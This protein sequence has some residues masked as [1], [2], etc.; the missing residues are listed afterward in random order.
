MA[1]EEQQQAPAPLTQGQVEEHLGAF[2][3]D[4][5]QQPVEPR[6]ER[7]Q[8]EQ[9]PQYEP[10]Q[11]APQ[12]QGQQE[13]PPSLE[14]DDPE[15]DWNGRKYKT[16]EL[17]R[18]L[19]DYRA[20]YADFQ[21]RQQAFNQ[22]TQGFTQ[23][24]QQAADM[25]GN[26]VKLVEQYMPRKPDPKL[27]ETDPF[28]YQSQRA[29]FEA[30]TEK[31][32]E[33]RGNER[34]FQDQ[35][36]AQQHYRYQQYIANQASATLQKLPELRDPVKFTKWTEELKTVATKHGYVPSDMASLRDHRLLSVFNDAIKLHRLE[37][38]HESLKAKL[39]VQQAEKP[40]PPVQQPQR[41]RSAATVQSENM[42]A[43]LTRLRNNP[44]SSQA[45]EDVLSR[46]D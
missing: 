9:E 28:A 46:F 12:E 24:Q 39:K 17:R 31:L 8:P 23:Y 45:A 10:Q 20:R 15:I 30:A 11:A 22:Q 5:P 32:E 42:R 36:R 18:G 21:R 27:A 13:P 6:Q 29:T 1:D 26:A 7:L 41:R 40:T 43:A 38:A 44:S 35:V 37:A 34:R 33:A 2:D 3:F 25:L 16:S 14:P 4:S 19:D